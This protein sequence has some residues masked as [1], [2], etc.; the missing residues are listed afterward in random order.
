[1][2]ETSNSYCQVVGIT[3][4][5]GKPETLESCFVAKLG[6]CVGKRTFKELVAFATD[7]T[8]ALSGDTAVVLSAKGG[9]IVSLLAVVEVE[10]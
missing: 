8:K 2:A 9:K 4:P 10:E 3:G 7:K 1:M 5:N 6:N